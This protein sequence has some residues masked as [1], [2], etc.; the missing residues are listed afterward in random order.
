MA[1][2][3]VLELAQALKLAI[4]ETAPIKQVHISRYDAKTPFN[5]T[6]RKAHQRP[7]LTCKF[8]QNGEPA[9]ASK[10]FDAE[11]EAV[12]KLKPGRYIN[13]KVEVIE[14]FDGGE[15]EIE[16]RYSNATPQQRME[17][18]NYWGNLT[19]LVTKIL[20]EQKAGEAKRAA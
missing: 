19:D 7:K 11:I 4:E 16:I 3:D 8:V 17:N 18:K 6:G 2:V 12:N 20:A 10:M 15:R 14:R 13:R 5:P 1:D 9:H